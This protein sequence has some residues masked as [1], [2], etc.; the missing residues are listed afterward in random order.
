MAVAMLDGPRL[1]LALVEAQVGSLVEVLPVAVLIASPFG[2]ILRANEAAID[3]FEDPLPL[4]GQFVS[5]V[6]DVAR[7]ARSLRVRLRWLHH[8]GEMLRLY[9]IHEANC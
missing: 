9:V 8:E 7:A 5:S 6:L 4:V 1:T 3:L 2:E